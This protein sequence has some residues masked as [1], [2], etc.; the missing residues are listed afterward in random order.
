M[1]KQTLIYVLSKD[2]KPLMPI[3]KPAKVRRWLRDGKAKVVRKCPF[4]IKLLF[5]TKGECLQDV[6]LGVDTG[7]KYVGVACM[8]NDKVL[9]QSQVELRGDIKNKMDDKR[10][11]RRNRRYRKTRYRK[12]RF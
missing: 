8:S 5:E 9:Y 3:K 4:T 10:M 12:P 11:Y 2:G 6:T 1:E 7:S